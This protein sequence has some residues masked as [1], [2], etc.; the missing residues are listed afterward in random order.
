MIYAFSNTLQTALLR[1]KKTLK[2][3]LPL[4]LSLILLAG[5]ETNMAIINDVDERDANEIVV[6]LASRGIP[7]EKSSSISTSPGATAGSPRYN[8]SVPPGKAT[9]AMAILNQNGLPRKQGTNLLELFAKAGLM[10]SEKE[11][12]VRY[13]AGLAMQI[14]NMILK[15]DG[16]I[17]ANVQLSFPDTSNAGLFGGAT[18][19]A[20]QQ[21]I[22]AAV[23]VKHQGILDDPNS[24]LI[25][26][27]KRLVAGSVT[28]LDVNDVTVISDRSRFTDISLA[29]QTEPLEAK[30]KEYVSIWS[31]VMNKDSAGR[32][33]MLFFL[34]TFCSILFALAI[35]WLVWKFYPLLKGKGVKQLLNPVP[36]DK[37]ANP[38]EGSVPHPEDTKSHKR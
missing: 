29:P 38:S 10:S 32:F 37:N 26:K 9:E 1:L 3:S 16:V 27:I 2:V 7:A 17:D 5:C 13:Q 6:F 14:A 31:I 12:T 34:L 28:G 19:A 15:I 8:I 4:I 36:I 33:R 30:A 18:T 20:P 22:T 35:G 21:K 24:H 25:T 23:Y 11:E